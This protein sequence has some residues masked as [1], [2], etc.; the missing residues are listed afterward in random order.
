MLTCT[1]VACVLMGKLLLSALSLMLSA[2][3]DSRTLGVLFSAS[4]S[5][6]LL[7]SAE[8]SEDAAGS[9]PSFWVLCLAASCPLPSCSAVLL[10]SAEASAFAWGVATGELLYGPIGIQA[11]RDRPGR[12]ML[13]M[14][15]LGKLMA[16]MPG[17][18]GSVMVGSQLL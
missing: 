1:P 15:T 7:A 5:A 3:A 18:L 16:G 10:L 9:S 2:G 11:G 6:N 12:L 8:A 17:M 14:G 4:R 13:G